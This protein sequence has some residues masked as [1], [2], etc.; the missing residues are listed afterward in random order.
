[1]PIGEGGRFLDPVSFSKYLR[2]N[3]TPAERNLKKHLTIKKIGYKFTSQHRIDKYYVDFCCRTHKVVV[4]LDGDSHDEKAET[5]MARD[6]ELAELGYVV[7]RFRNKDLEFID[8]VLER[9][10][11]ACDGRQPWRY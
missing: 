4:E 8:K 3:A 6:E 11:H 5:D 10:K 1:M 9:I 7:L 2:R